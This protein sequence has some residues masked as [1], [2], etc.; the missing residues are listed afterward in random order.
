MNYINKNLQFFSI[1]LILMFTLNFTSKAE[2]VDYDIVKK[3]ALNAFMLNSGISKSDLKITET[4]PISKDKIIV[5]YIFNFE[6]GHIVVSGDD[7]IIPVLGYDLTLNIDFANIPP[8]LLDLLNGFKDEILLA[9]KQREQTNKKIKEKWDYYLNLDEQT[10]L[11]SYSSGTYLL[12]TTWNQNAGYQQY[13]PTKPNSSI[14]CFVGCGGVALGQILKY[15]NCRVFPDGSN[16]YISKTI[17]QTLSVNYYDQNY[18]WNMSNNSPDDDNALLLYHSAVALSS[19]FCSDETYTSS[20]TDNASYAFVNYFGFHA[21]SPKYKDAYSD[22]TWINMLK[23]QIDLSYP[24]YYRGEGVDGGHAWVIDGYKND[25]TFHCNWGWG[26]SSNSWYSL[27]ALNAGGYQFNDHQAAILNI[28]PLLD[29]CSGLLG[30]YLICSS[31]T[32]YSVSIPPSASVTWSKSSNLMQVGGNTGNIY[33]VHTANSSQNGTGFV[34]ATIK[35]SQG[36]VF[37]IRNKNIWI[38]K[39]KFTVEGDEQLEIRMSGIAMLDYSNGGGNSNNVFWTRS[40]AITTVNGGPITA[41]FRAGSRPGM[42]A[43]YATVTNTCGSKENRLLVEVTGGWYSIYP[44]PAS[45][46]IYISVDKNKLPNNVNIDNIHF[47]LYDKMKVLKKQSV[48]KGYHSSI[49]VSEMKN[50]IYII[51]L[52]TGE[53]TYEEK[54]IISK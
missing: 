46:F 2:K 5:Y 30:P 48:L 45:D 16:T 14:K 42:G 36:N 7:I 43:V 20:S 37:L 15:W 31:N 18:N 23:T 26:G 10:A 3:I 39:P 38:G 17:N 49:N 54:I 1:V 40:G 34:K 47:K 25:N 33:T 12:T 35:N 19:D 50:G 27:S 11:K 28:Y 41:K 51:Q 13:C 6:K 4:I 21:D 22:N 44:N 52:I 8:G 24:I 9:K 53:K 32:S 29:A